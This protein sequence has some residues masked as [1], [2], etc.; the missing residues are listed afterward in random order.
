MMRHLQRIY[1]AFAGHQYWLGRGS[2]RL[3]LKCSLCGRETAGILV[4]AE[5]A[6]ARPA[7]WRRHPARHNNA[8][9]PHASEAPTAHR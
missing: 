9:G 4:G 6:P 2:D 5:E 8:A 1:C 3:F 7:W